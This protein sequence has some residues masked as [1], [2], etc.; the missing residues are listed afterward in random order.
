MAI[1]QVPGVSIAVGHVSGQVWAAGYG[2]MVGGTS[3]PLTVDTAFAACSIS[4]SPRGTYA[5]AW[6]GD[7]ELRYDNCWPIR[8]DCPTPGT[9]AMPRSLR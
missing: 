1:Y 8:R 2:V 5:I 7:R 4:T 9:A 3:T 6:V